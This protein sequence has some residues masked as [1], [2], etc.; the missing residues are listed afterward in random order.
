[1]LPVNELPYNIT[2]DH[3]S[4]VMS[5]I[6]SHRSPRKK[7][8]SKRNLIAAN[9]ALEVSRAKNR[10]EKGAKLRALELAVEQIT[11]IKIDRNY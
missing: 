6:G 1:M 4:K 8:S 7:E 5:W 2:K 11:E 3:V 9:T 10:A